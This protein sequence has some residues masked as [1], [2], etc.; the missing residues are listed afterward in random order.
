MSARIERYNGTPTLFVN[1]QPVFATYLWGKPPTAEGFELAECARQ[2]AK[3]GIHFYAFDLG[4]R[5]IVRE[6]CGPGPGHEG[7]FD[8]STVE[9]R[10]KHVLA[11]DPQA[12]FHLRIH[13]EMDSWW[14]DLYPDQCE[15]SAAGERQ[16]QSF[17]SPLW[18]EQA[19]DFMRAYVTHLK[20][21]GLF[22]RVIAYQALVGS[23]GEWVKGETAM[24]ARCGDYSAP[25]QHHFRAWLRQRYANDVATLQTAWATPN[26]TFDT[27]EVPPAAAQLSTTHHTFRDPTREQAVID[28]YRCLADLCASL[29][30]DF[31][32][33]VKEATNDQALFGVFF[34][35]LLELAWNA[36]FFGGGDASEFSSYQRS[37]HLALGQILRSPYVD[38]IAS[39][40]SYGFRGIGGAG[41]P[42]PPTE[43]LCL[44]N[45]LYIFEDD[46]RTYLAPPDAGYGRV[47]NLA[48]SES[49]LKRNLANVLSR[50]LAIWWS[51]SPNNIAP[52]AEPAFGSLLREFQDL[53]TWA[54]NL[55]RTPA[56]QITVLLDDESFYYESLHND[57]DVPL[58]F[59]Q[60]L[61][62]LA[63]IGAP[64]DYYLL[65]DFLEGRLPPY[66]LY[67]FLNTFRLDDNRRAALDRELKRDG[68][69]ALWIY[70]PGYIKDEPDIANMTDLTGFRFSKGEHVWGPMAH[71][72][73]FDHPITRALPQDLSWGTNNRLGPIFHL[74]DPEA[75]VLGQVVYSQ[76][77]CNPGFGIKTMPGWTSIYSAAPN[78]PAPVLRG[79]ARFAGVHLYNDQGDVLYAT[80]QLLGIHTVAGGERTFDLPRKVEIVYDLFEHHV[81]A[82]DTAQFQVT[83]SPKSSAL[84]YTGDANLLDQLRI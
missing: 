28:Y 4:S 30:N 50:G 17:A 14:Q 26:V 44:H 49:V 80:P 59:Q 34:G 67:I 33:A 48:E 57:L 24:S 84:Y 19:K 71:I 75:R 79:I 46:T 29:V 21:I 20:S 8:F 73:D 69:V 13:L 3:A 23:A 78:I 31:G 63:R 51:G 61:W 35:Y 12:H 32:R 15:W 68:R 58:I 1:D 55:N 6:W 74:E 66:K 83:L 42:M 5:G 52:D 40:Y 76:G 77:R 70:A 11:I 41:D 16:H 7:H 10:L 38:F 45:K 47:N 18:R 64:V 22:D 25:M 2:Y 82:Q 81:V 65:Q 60:R 54:L 53:G 36:S 62:G 39:P 43:S 56:S 27:A 9:A 72:L 37:G